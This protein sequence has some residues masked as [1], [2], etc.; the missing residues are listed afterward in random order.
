[1]ESN[2]F[3]V[4][5]FSGQGKESRDSGQNFDA[6]NVANSGQNCVENPMPKMINH[7]IS[8]K[9]HGNWPPGRFFWP[10]RCLWPLFLATKRVAEARCHVATA[11]KRP[12]ARGKWPVARGKWPVASGSFSPVTPKSPV[13]AASGYSGKYSYC[14]SYS[15]IVSMILKDIFKQK[16]TYSVFLIYPSILLS[17]RIL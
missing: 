16:A 17:P 13:A 1:M 15:Y 8:S 4:S 12:V 9:I 14:W 3:H 6:K 10:F 7:G 11:T 2:D 5:R